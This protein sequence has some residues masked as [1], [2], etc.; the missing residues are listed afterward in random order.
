VTEDKRA[1]VMSY[2]TTAF[3]GA[4]PLGSLL[5]GALAHRIGAPNTVILTGTFCVAARY[6]SRWSCQQ[7]EPRF[8]QSIR[9]TGL[10]PVPDIDPA[11]DETV[12]AICLSGEFSRKEKHN[13]AGLLRDC[14]LSCLFAPGE[15]PARVKVGGDSAEGFSSTRRRIARIRGAF[16][17]AIFEKI[18]GHKAGQM[19]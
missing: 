3:F 11:S 12:S 16:R 15:R 19:V 13:A 4:A 14:T 2:Y 18:A 7:S 17:R 5:A 1:R 10:V 6:G 9:K 8:G